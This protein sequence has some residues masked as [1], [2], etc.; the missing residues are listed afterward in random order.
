MLTS[1]EL[2]Q[3]N[4]KAREVEQVRGECIGV[5]DHLGTK[6]ALDYIE[7]AFLS[8]RSKGRVLRHS[9]RADGNPSFHVP[10]FYVLDGTLPTLIPNDKLARIWPPS[11]EGFL[12]RR[13]PKPTR[14]LKKR[15]R[16]F[17]LLKGF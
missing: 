8:V 9:A 13:L 17:R 6:E 4:L 11:V 16:R 12:G 14:V 7:K 1:K 5:L 15:E 2:P 10:H 3:D